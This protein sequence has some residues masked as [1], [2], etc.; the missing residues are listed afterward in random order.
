MKKLL[1][2]LMSA[3]PLIAG[4]QR[5][6]VRHVLPV[7][8]TEN[9]DVLAS[10]VS[11]DDLRILFTQQGYKGL[12]LIDLQKG[13]SVVISDDP[14]S[15]Y[16]PVFSS[17]SRKIFFRSDVIMEQKKYSSLN[18]YNLETGS[19]IK[20]QPESRNLKSPAISGNKVFWS[21]DNG[22]KE[23]LSDPTAKS[24]GENETFIMLEDLTPVLYHGKN[25][26]VITPNGPGNYIWVSLSPDKTKILYNF[27]GTCTYISDTTGN[28]L[29]TAGRINAPRW[30][31]NDII[32][33]MDDRDDGHIVISSDIVCFLLKSGRTINLT[34]TPSK[35]EM[36]PLPFSD[37]KK[38][39][40]NTSEGGLFIMTL[41]IRR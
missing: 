1:I 41:R 10:A 22:M 18:E 5:V 17:D 21:S 34:S 13:T 16:E 36:Y 23:S 35:I 37:G 28:I 4:G 40:F 8:G 6:S 33:G 11:P 29:A 39:V 12:T 31:N 19:R 15:G 2:M 24:S 3:L 32:I 9:R 38:V 7:A 20:L 14:G 25:R 30:L 26:K 27:G